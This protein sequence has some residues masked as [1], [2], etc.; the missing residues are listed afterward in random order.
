MRSFTIFQNSAFQTDQDSLALECILAEKESITWLDIGDPTDDDLAFLKGVFDFHP[1]AL[2]DAI[3]TGERPKVDV[4]RDYYSIV[5]YSTFYD[6]QNQKIIALPFH[7]FI[8]ANYLVTIHQGQIHQ[9]QETLERWQ[10]PNSP[11]HHSVGALVHSLL[12]AVVDDY[13]PMIDKIAEQVEDL[14]DEIFR[15]HD[16]DAIQ[17]IFALKK[18][19]LGLRRILAPERDVLNVLLRRQLTIFKSKDVV[20][21]QD[22]YDHIVRITESTDTYRDLLSSA[23]DSYLSLQSNKLN[24]I[25]KLLTIA[26]II[27]MSNSLIA[28]IYGMNFQFMPELQWQIGYPFALALMVCISAGLVFYFR[29]QR[30]L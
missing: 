15:N 19:I 30:W 24:Q 22:V 12:D 11:V 20:Y 5:F 13:F 16:D 9:I 25:V 27:L 8:G 10:L 14:E 3:R 7:L 26:S 17:Q 2:E 29:Q 28:G 23:L 6:S 1:L 21:L 4:H 18:E